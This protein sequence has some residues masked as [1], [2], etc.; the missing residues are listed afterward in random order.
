MN[1]QY[2]EVNNCKIAYTERNKDA[3]NTI[4]FIPG[5]SVSKKIWRKQFSSDALSAYFCD[6]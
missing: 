6:D 1:S 2:L 4:F 5:N 3:A